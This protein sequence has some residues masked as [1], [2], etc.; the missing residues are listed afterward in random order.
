M[1]KWLMAGLIG[2][3]CLFS[4][5]L[6]VWN[7]PEKEQSAGEV[8]AITIPDRD[9]DA[10]AAIQIYRSSCLSCH[11]DQMQGAYGPELAHI[12]SDQTK[13]QIYRTVMNGRRGMPS[14]EKRL[15]EDEIITVAT[16]LSSLK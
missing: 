7:M 2:I 14:F 9:V 4:V 11:G 12:G 1:G 15:T 6:L 13:E 10:D 16:W 5:Y 3:A 8:T